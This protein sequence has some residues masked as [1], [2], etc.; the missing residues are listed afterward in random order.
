M[1]RAW[2]K[3]ALCLVLASALVLTSGCG[4]QETKDKSPDE[5]KEAS[6]GK[7]NGS[8]GDSTDIAM[9][10]YGENE[11]D[12]TEELEVVTGMRKMPDGRLVITDSSTGVLES[13][14]N[15]ATWEKMDIPWLSEK[16]EHSYFLDI[17]M[18]SDGTLAV[19]YESYE[20]EDDG[21]VEKEIGDEGEIGDGGV[22]SDGEKDGDEDSDEEEG[23][24][25]FTLDP[26]C[27]L[28]K[29]DGTVI[30]VDVPISEEEMYLH[31]I[32]IS[33]AGRIFVSTV[34]GDNI[35]EIKEDGSC[36]LF[37]T[38]Q[39]RPELLQFQDNLMI[40]DGYDYPAPVLFDMDK[41][42]VLEKEEL[43]AFMEENYKDRMFNGGSW[44]DMYL[45]PGEEGELYFAGRKGLHRYRM[46]DGSMEQLIDGSLSRLGSP[47]FNLKS[48]IL[49]EDG[50]FLAV[51]SGGKLIRF[52]YDPDMPS[53]PSESLK[54]YS[55]TDSYGIRT[56][57][58][59]Y[60][61]N[62]PEVY[63]E[64]EVGMAEGGAVTREDA[65]KKLNTQIM[66]G[67]GP[68]LLMMDGMPMDSYMEKG[69]L[70]D[71]AGLMEEINQEEEL[72][73]NL[74]QAMA[75]D[76]KV[77][78]VPMEVY[79][80]AVLGREEYV[81]EIKDLTTMADAVCKIREDQPG[82]D[83]IYSTNGKAVLKAFAPVAAP[84]WKDDGGKID[85]ETLSQFLTQV[86][87]IYD[88]QMDGLNEKSIE[89]HELTDSYYAAEEGEDWMY[90]ILQYGNNEIYFVGDYQQFSIG[91]SSYPYGYWELTSVAKNPGFEDAMWVPAKGLCEKV[92]VPATMLGINAAS[93]RIDRAKEFFREFLGKEVQKALG[94]YV[95]NKKA[96]EETFQPERDYVGENGEYGSLATIDEDGH[97]TMLTVYLA[98]QEEM[99][100]FWQWIGTADTPYIEDMVL[101]KAVFEEGEKYLLG[102]QDLD[103]TLD[104]IMQ[105]LSIYLSE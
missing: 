33:D 100:T 105:Q 55:L 3:K 46:E 23:V 1:K 58:S 36:A 20:E 11:T 73:E 13:K 91:V 14:D 49:L 64:Y 42:E 63:V 86:K 90:D 45:F 93:S 78:V 24:S 70:L 41:K 68:D 34:G 35:Y 65:L 17:Q 66:A 50:E 76:G 61:I 48:M 95:I 96:L 9:G 22:S 25:A 37:F 62:H 47:L 19:I 31:K 77:Y 59:L 102:E 103:T 83:I 67:E 53:V 51:S 15:G 82:K 72:F 30:P 85:R 94:S 10:R 74:Y 75:K 69:M 71:L 16:L 84:M 57:I 99:D 43:S 26:V 27:E 12:L 92:F 38:A 18:A 32:G 40:V 88:A 97:T 56:A 29:P 8:S 79:L 2:L 52:T 98:T 104:A 28:V 6:V 4:E 89:E 87:R 80:P 21:D 101:E 7:T 5:G 54:V 39:G 44:Y 60:Q 81:S